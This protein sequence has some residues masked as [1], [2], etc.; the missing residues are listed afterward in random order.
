MGTPARR[1]QKPK[2][3]WSQA[4][5]DLKP[6]H[7]R[8]LQ[9]AQ[10]GLPLL[11]PDPLEPETYI[12]IGSLPIKGAVA[13]TLIRSLQHRGLIDA[14]GVITAEGHARLAADVAANQ[15]EC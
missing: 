15:G 9:L 3:K 13:S 6:S 12:P 4:S 10:P 7:L 11:K 2:A 1:I 8:M 5:V 14:I